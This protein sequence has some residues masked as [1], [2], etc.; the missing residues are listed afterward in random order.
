MTKALKIFIPIILALIL[1]PSLDAQSKRKRKSKKKEKKKSSVLRNAYQDMTARYNGYFNA[2]LI[3]D[4]S[5]LA[6]KESNKDDF[7]QTLALFDFDGGDAA[8][9]THAQMNKIIEKCSADIILHPN[10]KWVDDCYLLLGKARFFKGEYEEA[11]VN[12]NY[13]ERKFGRSL[14][15]G[16]KQKKG[17]VKRNRSLPGFDLGLKMD[18]PVKADSGKLIEDLKEDRKKKKEE[19]E[20]ARKEKEKDNKQLKKERAKDKKKLQKEREKE[21]KRKEKERARIKKMSKE[22]RRAYIQEQK[23]KKAE[24][25]AAKLAEEAQAENDKAAEEKAEKAAEEKAAKEAEAEKAAAEKA[26]EEEEKKQAEEKKEDEL[27]QYD[28]VDSDLDKANY[29]KNFLGFLRHKAAKYEGAIWKA[30]TL[31]SVDRADEA[32]ALLEDVRSEGKMPKK[33]RGELNALYAS[34]FLHNEDP[35]KAYA[36]LSEAIKSTKGKK[37]KARLHFV[38]AQLSHEKEEY[39]LALKSYKRVLKSKPSFEMEFHSR[40]QIAD[41]KMRSGEYT[42]SRVIKDLEKMLKEEKYKNNQ[43]Q[44]Y[45]M[46]ANIAIEGGDV[47]QAMEYLAQSASNSTVNNDMK[48]RA[49]LALAELHFEQENYLLSS[50]YYDSTANILP[51]DYP[52]I[53]DIISRKEILS[54]LA[55]HIRTV[56]YEDSLQ[57]LAQLP[58]DVRNKIIDD[59]ID[60]LEQQIEDERLA[61]EQAANEALESQNNTNGT[62]TG[63]WYFYNDAAKSMGYNQFVSLWGNRQLADDWRRGGGGQEADFSNRS[64]SEAE[65]ARFDLAQ[66][67]KLSREAFLDDIPFS[68][69]AVEV[70]N[71]KIKEALF[72]SGNIYKD[73]LE[74]DLKAIDAFT[75]LNDRFPAN[76]HAIAAAYSLYLLHKKAG[77]TAKAEQYKK[78]ILANDKSGEYKAVLEDPAAFAKRDKEAEKYYEETYELYLAE[79]YEEVKNRKTEAIAMFASNSNL[80]PQFDLLGAFVVGQTEKKE[81]YIDALKLVKDKYPSHNVGLKAAEILEYISKE[82]KAEKAKKKTS[83]FVFKEKT[84]HYFVL[85]FA[86]Y[87]EDINPTII[88]FS[89]HNTSKFKVERLKVT[90]MLLS[91]QNQIVLVKT[92][93]N[94]EKALTYFKQTQAAIPDLLEG[95]PTNN[96]SP[97]VISKT[98]FAKFFKSKDTES[99]LEFFEENYLNN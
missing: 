64:E 63:T 32:I 16:A 6:L 25:E 99:Y 23:K 13:I 80:L 48:A 40:L 24:E 89:D 54:E 12:F 45:F 35:A 81:D 39:D 52:E 94:A 4:E 37:K 7:S 96:F 50:I 65:Q 66:S 82:E 57:R 98:N 73:K 41:T 46:M 83:Q 17:K 92:F 59:L 30:R 72:G 3:L 93:P 43:D 91:P 61:A 27:G 70:S 33:F 90:P 51:K 74:N 1:M 31:L 60:D 10:S 18:G 44:I 8:S 11:L 26:K 38:Q 29:E 79:Q 20:K 88:K 84:P 2:K 68:D 42:A 56:E 76:K 71:E 75:S 62:G 67:G 21:K 78:Y 9:S 55:G 53:E 28:L 19:K 47:E 36:A 77:N 95:V 86:E 85:A 14:R 5:L 22:K 69:E 97:F 15:K 87:V 49:Y 58:E 34:A